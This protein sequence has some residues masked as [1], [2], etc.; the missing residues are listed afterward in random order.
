[1]KATLRIYQFFI[2]LNVCYKLLFR[3]YKHWVVFNLDD[4]NLAKLLKEE[5]DFDVDATYCYLQPYIISQMVKH[6][7]MNKSDVDLVLDKAT[8]E[9]EAEIKYGNKS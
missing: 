1:M 7:A 5:E 9:A 8:F 3:K 4:E 6:M 2:R